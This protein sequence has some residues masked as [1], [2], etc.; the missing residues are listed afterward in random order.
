MWCVHVY[1]FL[2]FPGWVITRSLAWTVSDAEP[3]ASA[4]TIGMRCWR[5][6][7]NPLHTGTPYWSPRNQKKRFGSFFISFVENFVCLFKL[8]RVEVQSLPPIIMIQSMPEFSE[9]PLQDLILI[10]QWMCQMI[11]WWC[12]IH[13]YIYIYTVSHVKKGCKTIKVLM[14]NESL[15]S[16]NG[17]AASFCCQYY[18]QKLFLSSLFQWKTRTASFDSQG[19]CPSPK[20]PASPWMEPHVPQKAW[21]PFLLSVCVPE[22]KNKKQQKVNQNIKIP[23]IARSTRFLQGF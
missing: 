9:D 2:P 21:L 17:L 8:G 22:E 19:S 5:T 7:A 16:E 20:A 10:I 12:I 18:F 11:K 14:F 23:A 4:E 15:L 6:R 13:L 3:R 1:S